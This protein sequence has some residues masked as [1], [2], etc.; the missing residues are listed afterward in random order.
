VAI[1]TVELVDRRDLRL[2][3]G[4]LALSMAWLLASATGLSDG[5]V[6]LAPALLL[7]L[8]LLAGRYV[9]ERTLERLRTSRTAATPPRRSAPT[10]AL[11]R[12]ALTLIARGGLLL[13]SSLATR[14]PPVRG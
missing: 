4:L 13:A 11:P 14:P 10:F 5:L 9:G 7:A 6:M 8:P 12:P 1:G 3:L 2:A